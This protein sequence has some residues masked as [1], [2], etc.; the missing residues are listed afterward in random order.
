MSEAT[1]RVIANKA[2]LGNQLARAQLAAEGTEVIK[3]LDEVEAR[4]KLS[5]IRID[6]NGHE[7]CAGCDAHLSRVNKPDEHKEDCW[8]GANK[9]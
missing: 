2:R 6:Q 9:V 1:L 3:L 7:R 4:R 5:T 8:F